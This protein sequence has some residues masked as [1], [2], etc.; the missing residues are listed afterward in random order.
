[1]G[2]DR[3]AAVGQRRHVDP[4]GHDDLEDGVAGQAAGHRDG[5][6]TDAGDVADLA[7]FGVPPGEGV[8]VDPHV[9]RVL[10]PPGGQGPAGIAQPARLR[11]QLHQAVRVGTAVA[12]GSNP[13]TMTW[14]LSTTPCS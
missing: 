2:G 5:D 3:S 11:E 13:L 14:R 6:G 12:A 7:V 8:V 4:V 9:V 1:M 10:H